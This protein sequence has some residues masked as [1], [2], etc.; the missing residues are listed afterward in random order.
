MH[1]HS[2]ASFDCTVAPADVAR[3]LSRWGLRPVFLTDHDTVGGARRLREEGIVPVVC[4]QEVTTGD[5]D[6]IGLF[7]SRPVTPHRGAER[8]A[9]EVREQGGL[10]YLPHPYDRRRRS[11]SEAAIERL[12]D[13]IDIVEVH[14][15]RSR[16]DDNRRAEELCEILG[17]ARG[18]GSDAHTLG[19]LGGV[20][21]ELEDFDG[22]WDFLRKLAGAR[23]V[24]RPSRLR[25]RLE[26]TLAIASWRPAA[27]P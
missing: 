20:Y 16:D 13:A 23:I 21:V 7:L 24:V 25:M 27:P 8:A 19:E 17:A 12:R 10:V 3:E 4:G 9:H 18:A 2:S 11:L 14:N 26:R 22:P 5:G 15:G 1:V 6:L